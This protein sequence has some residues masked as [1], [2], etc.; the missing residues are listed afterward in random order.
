MD[1]YDL[2]NKYVDLDEIKLI[3]KEGSS[4]SLYI[5]F[6]S[7]MEIIDNIKNDGIELSEDDEN[8]L[9]IFIDEMVGL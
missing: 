8:E 7:I 9:I 6:Y 4:T 3:P 2:F 1:K 5:D